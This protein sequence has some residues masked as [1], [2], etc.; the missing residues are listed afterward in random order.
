MIENHV[1][2]HKVISF[3]SY[4]FSDFGLSVK[5][6]VTLLINHF[7]MKFLFYIL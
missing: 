3:V 4:L 6:K 1:V 5:Q 2:E 7:K